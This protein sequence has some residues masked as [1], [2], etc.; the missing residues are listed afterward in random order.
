MKKDDQ[1]A[2]SEKQKQSPPGNGRKTE[3]V[4]ADEGREQWE[5]KNVKN[6]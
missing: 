4:K 1:N 3:K 2:C 6:K 5:C